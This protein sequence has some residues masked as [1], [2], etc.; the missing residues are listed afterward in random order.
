MRHVPT[1]EQLTATL[2]SLGTSA[3]LARLPKELTGLT[4][5]LSGMLT[6][7][8]HLHREPVTDHLIRHATGTARPLGRFAFEPG[9]LRQIPNRPSPFP[10]LPRHAALPCSEHP[11]THRSRQPAQ[12]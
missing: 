7:R 10:Y 1:Y 4:A 8:L 5:S 2:D 9:A 11:G 3:V 6:N 12:H